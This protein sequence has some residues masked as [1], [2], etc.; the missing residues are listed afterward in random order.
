MEYAQQLRQALVNVP[1]GAQLFTVKGNRPSCLPGPEN[2]YPDNHDSATHGYLSVLSSS[3]VNQVLNKF[4]TRQDPARSDLF[5]AD[6]PLAER[7]RMALTLLSEF[8]REPS[9]AERDPLSPL[10][11]CC[12]TDEVRKSQE[13][14]YHIYSEGSQNA[15]S[16][17][18]PDGRPL[19]KYVC[20]SHHNC[21]I[22]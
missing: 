1:N 15:L 8:K 14:L 21:K 12:V 11:F 9:I 5:A 4:L 19:R 6:V 10:S 18:A 7:M 17:L 20:V 22:D 2:A 13:E 16:P 3:I